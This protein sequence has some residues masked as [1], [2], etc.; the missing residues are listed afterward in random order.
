MYRFPNFICT[1]PFNGLI[2]LLLIKHPSLPC[3]L[4][5]VEAATPYID[6]L[7]LDSPFGDSSAKKSLTDKLFEGRKKY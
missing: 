4:G 7:Y 1:P 5:I 3:K 6:G 2:N